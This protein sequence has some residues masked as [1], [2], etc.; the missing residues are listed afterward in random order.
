MGSDDP[1]PNSDTQA[2]A[3]PRSAIRPRAPKDWRALAN[4][5]H[6]WYPVANLPSEAAAVEA[7]LA[8]C[9]Q[10]DTGCRLHAISNFRVADR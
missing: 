7:A 8:Q 5:A 9:A 10:R 6:G 2:D 1:S 3:S 4:G